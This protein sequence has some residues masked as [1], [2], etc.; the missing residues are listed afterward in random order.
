MSSKS[1]PFFRTPFNYDTD[2]VSNETGLLCEDVSLAKQE[3]AD[4]CDINTIVRRFGITGTM[5]SSVSMPVFA[6]FSGMVDDYHS[7]VNL[8]LA[9][10][11][12]FM[13]I[14]AEVRAK[15]DNDPGRFVAFCS[16]ANNADKMRE[17]GLTNTPF[18]A[19]VDPVVDPTANSGGS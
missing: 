2:A 11:D 3:F 4:E 9:A 17:F 8:V 15:F 13:T 12:A 7:A 18:V 5:P 14:P 6:D 1:I 19:K 10:D 16:D